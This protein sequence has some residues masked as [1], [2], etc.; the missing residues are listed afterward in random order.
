MS[1][2]RACCCCRTRRVIV[3]SAGVLGAAGH[4]ELVVVAK[5]CDQI[6]RE[7]D[8]AVNGHYFGTRVAT[9]CRLIILVFELLP[10]QLAATL[11]E[12]VELVSFG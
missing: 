5:A 3:V 4:V 11:D 6:A 12:L 2:S 1:V 7:I 9:V 8:V 10:G